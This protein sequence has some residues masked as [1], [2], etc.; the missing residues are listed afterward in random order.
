MTLSTTDAQSE[1]RGTPIVIPN[2]GVGA[3]GQLSGWLVDDQS[4]VLAGERIAEVLV[5]GVLVD[6]LSPCGGLCHWEAIPRGSRLESG[7]SIGAILADDRPQK[8]D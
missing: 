3:W 1:T 4:T 6:I 8:C 5:Q 7:Q 2:L